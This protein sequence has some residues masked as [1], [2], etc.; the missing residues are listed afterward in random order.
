MQDRIA[1]IMSP[2]SERASRM[3]LFFH[4]WNKDL[5]KGCGKVS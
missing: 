1:A 3:Y 4:R 5:W 2:V